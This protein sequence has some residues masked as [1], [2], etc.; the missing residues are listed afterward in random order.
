MSAEIQR[1]LA[2]VL[3]NSK[4][5]GIPIRVVMHPDVLERMKRNDATL[6][7]EMEKRYRNTLSFRADPALHY[8]DFYLI[9]P[10]TGERLE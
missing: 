9:D 3:K 6:L 2:M 4:L 7:Q 10:Q 1:H 8:E 5:R